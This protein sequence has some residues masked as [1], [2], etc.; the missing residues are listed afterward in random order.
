MDII[1]QR[2]GEMIVID[3]LSQQFMQALRDT[4]REE[5][6][7]QHVEWVQLQEEMASKY[8][9]IPAREVMDRTVICE[10]QGRG[11]RV[12]KFTV[13]ERLPYESRFDRKIRLR[14]NGSK[15][16]VYDPEDLVMVRRHG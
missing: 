13:T 7:R 15:L 1:S 16:W 10:Q 14:V 11:R 12:V 3:G 9:W 4:A 8:A 5:F 6:N 2:V